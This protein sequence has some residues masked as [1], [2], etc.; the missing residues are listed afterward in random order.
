[1]TQVLLRDLDE[2]SCSLWVRSRGSEPIW[3][4]FISSY[5]HLLSVQDKAISLIS[6]CL[7]SQ[8]QIGNRNDAYLRILL[9][10]LIFIK[11]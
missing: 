10:G 9:H 2:K 8:L 11:H 4:G 1:M 5:S 7:L 3:P 6:Y